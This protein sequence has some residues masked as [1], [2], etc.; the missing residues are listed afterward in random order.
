MKKNQNKTTKLRFSF[1][2]RTVGYV[3]CVL[4]ITLAIAVVLFLCLFVFGPM[5]SEL[6]P[7]SPILFIILLNIFSLI[8][9]FLLSIILYRITFKE[10]EDFDVGMKKVGKG[11]FSVRLEEREN[12]YMS[13]LN[14]TFNAMVTSLNSIETLK[15]DFISNFSHEFKTPLSSVSGFAKLLKKGDLTPEESKEYIDIIISEA[16]RLVQLSK[17]TLLMS[18]LDNQEALYEKKTYFLDEQLRKCALLFQTDIDKKQINLSLEGED[19]QYYGSQDLTQ[20]LWINLIGNA[21]KFTNEGGAISISIDKTSEFIEVK[22]ADTGIGMS[23][24][25]KQ[26]IFDK[27]FQ[28]DKSH[29]TYGNGLGLSICK[30]IIEITGGSIEVESELGQG[31][32]FIVKLP[33]TAEE[34]PSTK[35]K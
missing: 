7:M 9:G 1:F 30:K 21:V 35:Q 32:T 4:T 12:S 34:K 28:G 25:T 20:Q 15:T 2:Q 17:N 8:M 10:L 16:E 14:H 24:E 26:R 23:A 31:S 5:G 6:P 13:E 22:I 29:T 27:F 19:I 18:R 11:D 3:L 33:I